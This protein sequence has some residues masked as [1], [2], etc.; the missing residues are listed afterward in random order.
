MSTVRTTTPIPAVLGAPAT[1]ANQE[2][3]MDMCRRIAAMS[4]AEARAF[5]KTQNAEALR[6]A[7][8]A[9]ADRDRFDAELKAQVA[10][11]KRGDPAIVNAHPAG[12]AVRRIDTAA[13]YTDR[14][15]PRT[16]ATAPI[17]SPG[18]TTTPRSMGSVAGGYYRGQAPAGSDGGAIA[19]SPRG[20][21]Q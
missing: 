6:R 11:C 12:R 15:R 18:S 4:P 1:L 9:S 5:A 13:V 21:G 7:A 17:A 20:G 3:A 14:A 10:A 19:S 8:A 16:A 2:A